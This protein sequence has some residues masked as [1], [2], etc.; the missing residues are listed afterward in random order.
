MRKTKKELIGMY[1]GPCVLELIRT[2][3]LRWLV[4]WYEWVKH[5]QQNKFWLIERQ[6]KEKETNQEQ[7]GLQPQK[8][9]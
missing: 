1:G 4:M 2:Q 6:E 5:S 3:R 8:K 9:M 7:N